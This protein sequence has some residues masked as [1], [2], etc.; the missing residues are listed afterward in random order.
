MS[1]AGEI[2]P[3]RGDGATHV[4]EALK[5]EILELTLPPGSPLDETGLSQRFG[6][7]R[8]PVREALV[9][10]AADGFATTLPNRNT[11]VT[12]IDFAALPA[13]VDA[14]TL[15]YRLT[16]RLAALNRTEADLQLM[17]GIQADYAKAVAA[18]DA[19]GMIT[20]NKAF[21]LAVARAG[22]NHYYADLATRVLDD[23]SRLLRLYYRS[24]E[25][26]LPREFVDEHGEIIAAIK[27][28]DADRADALGLKHAGQIVDRLR[29]FLA[30]QAGDRIAL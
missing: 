17:R 13:F 5:R 3:A 1:E 15:V 25:D 6:L 22:R 2:R 11:I 18:A 19:I 29:G 14:L 21:H 24:F 30:P 16:C 4:Y 20:I 7:S 27:A 10:L 28:R 23:G 26:H 8:T 12:P 9:K